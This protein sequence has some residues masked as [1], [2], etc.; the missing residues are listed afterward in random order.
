MNIIAHRGYSAKYP[1][2]TLL[3]FEKVAQLPIAGVELDVHLTSDRKLV[4]THD[5]CLERTSNGNGFVK[6]KTLAELQQYDFGAWFDEQFAGQKIATLDEVLTIFKDTQHH[7][8]IE[9]KTD[10]FE[11][12]GIEALVAE[13][14][15]QHHF[16]DRVTI[17][18]FNHESLIRFQALKS[19]I[20]TATLYG[21]LI[22]DLENYNAS[23]GSDAMHIY[24]YHTERKIIQQAIANGKAIRTFTVNDVQI[25]KLLKSRGVEAVF[26]DDPVLMLEH[27]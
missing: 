19:G 18:S 10:I 25:A 22:I 13:T 24:Y 27:L 12:E 14:V 8:H 16:L 2:N 20:P 7:I 4:V 21:S 3:A 1:E 9:L 5:E 6:D 26:T 23:I 17:S 15:K 11:Y